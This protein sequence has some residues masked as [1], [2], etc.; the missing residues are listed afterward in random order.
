MYDVAVGVASMAETTF[1]PAGMPA[2]VTLAQPYPVRG[3]QLGSV[4][5]GGGGGDCHH[6]D[7]KD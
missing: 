7:G 5:N 3:L 2:G 6:H 4:L 1:S